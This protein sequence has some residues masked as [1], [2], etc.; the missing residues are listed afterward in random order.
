MPKP[1]AA[2][3]ADLL[4]ELKSMKA[5]DQQDHWRRNARIKEAETMTEDTMKSLLATKPTTAQLYGEV[6]D[7][8]VA[9]DILNKIQAPEQ[10][11]GWMSWLGKKGGRT[12]KVRRRKTTRRRR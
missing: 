8:R 1:F 3:K 6:W 2:A 7:Y 12:R 4:A 11:R 9:Q 10:K 5:E